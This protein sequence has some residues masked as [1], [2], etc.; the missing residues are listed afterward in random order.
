MLR[1]IIL[2][3]ATLVCTAAV[4]IEPVTVKVLSCYDGDTC[5]ADAEI[6]PGRDRIRLANADAPEIEGQCRDEINRAIEARDYTRALVA[7]KIV[8][9]TAIE[10]DKYRKRV[11]AYVRLPDGRDLGD[12]LIAAGLARPY[13]GEQRRSWCQ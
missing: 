7:G 10:P 4:A 1:P 3:L 5:R 2:V 6:L 12:A 9:L 13:S 8:T 11:D